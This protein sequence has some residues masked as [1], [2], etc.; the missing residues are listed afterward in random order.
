MKAIPLLL[1]ILTLTSFVPLPEDC[2]SERWKVK[3]VT[4]NVQIKFSSPISRSITQLRM[5]IRPIKVGKQA[6]RF[7]FEKNVVTTTGNIVY[8]K[9]EDDKDLHVVIQTGKKNMI[10]EFPD[11]TCDAMS[12]SPVVDDA[13]KAKADFLKIVAGKPKDQFF[14][15]IPV[16]VKGVA[17]FDINHGEPGQIG[18][19]PNN[20][21]LHPVLSISLAH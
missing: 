13:T 14:E 4:D 19:A 15:G 20:M 7:P 6:D 5:V 2:G 10:I 17:F 11:V 16:R 18:H 21:E 9:G 3:T 8:Y 1:I 12:R